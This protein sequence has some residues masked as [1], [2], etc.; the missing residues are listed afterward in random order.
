MGRG[1]GY[2]FIFHCH[3]E[4]RWC[5]FVVSLHFEILFGD[6]A[7]QSMNDGG[8]GKAECHGVDAVNMI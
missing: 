2:G 1:D 6:R 5:E 4:T 3:L 7:A 8:S